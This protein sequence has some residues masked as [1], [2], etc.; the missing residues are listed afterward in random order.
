MFPELGQDA[1]FSV[2]GN[3]PNHTELPPGNWDRSSVGSLLL[4]CKGVQAIVVLVR[5][6]FRLACGQNRIA[7]LLFIPR[8]CACF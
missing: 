4:K 2:N 7:R 5:F 6:P 3:F 8:T 1:T